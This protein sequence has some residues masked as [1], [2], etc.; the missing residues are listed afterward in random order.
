MAA[1]K[2]Q[3]KNLLKPLYIKCEEI[4]SSKY[5][6][7]DAEKK[8]SAKFVLISDIFNFLRYLSVADGESSKQEVHYIMGILGITDESVVRKNIINTVSIVEAEISK[9]PRFLKKI[10]IMENDGAN[11]LASEIV[12]RFFEALGREFI[13]VDDRQ[14]GDEKVKLASYIENLRSYRTTHLEIVEGKGETEPL[15]D[16]DYADA[17]AHTNTNQ[18]DFFAIDFNKPFDN[19]AYRIENL[20]RLSPGIIEFILYRL[21]FVAYA[22]SKQ[23]GWVKCHFVFSGAHR[24]AYSKKMSQDDQGGIFDEYVSF[25]EKEYRKTD[26]AKRLFSPE[27]Q[28]LKDGQIEITGNGFRI[29]FS[30]NQDAN[31]LYAAL[32]L[33]DHYFRK[34]VSMYETV[35]I[36][37]EPFVMDMG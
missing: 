7:Y 21:S 11:I 14:T 4:D 5:A 32:F 33:S 8:Q 15:P 16:E 17:N 13:A 10:I 22:L 12:I 18:E 23:D 36:D 19:K 24:V 1:A 26:F 31:S 37:G 9:T 28:V 20:S 29:R 35:E 25:D 3:V 27:I 34:K 2:L 30:N 6:F